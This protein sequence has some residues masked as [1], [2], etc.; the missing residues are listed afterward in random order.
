MEKD[1]GYGEHDYGSGF[2]RI[3]NEKKRICPV[4][5]NPIIG[6]PFLS[7]RDGKTEICSACG[8]REAWEDYARARRF[9]R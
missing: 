6:Y 7:R 9:R 3:R 5:G 4:C 1:I 2:V 8:E